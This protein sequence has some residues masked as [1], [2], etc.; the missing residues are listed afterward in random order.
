MG[1]KL[2]NWPILVICVNS[3][4]L[5]HVTKKKSSEVGERQLPWH[6]V[7]DM[8]PKSFSGMKRTEK[9]RNYANNFM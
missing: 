1:F 7:E 5:L 8:R 2:C 6:E 4:E 3:K 9:E